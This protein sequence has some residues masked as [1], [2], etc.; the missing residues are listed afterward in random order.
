MALALPLIAARAPVLYLQLAIDSGEQALL[1]SHFHIL[2][3]GSG[4][5][6]SY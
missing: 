1:L 3:E 2:G 5:V 6:L 4:P